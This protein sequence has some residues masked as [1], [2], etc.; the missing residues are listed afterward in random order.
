MV[1]A[2]PDADQQE[3]LLKESSGE[4][5]RGTSEVLK[6]VAKGS[7]AYPEEFKAE[8]E[9]WLAV[10][11]DIE[12]HSR[13]WVEPFASSKE[14]SD[15]GRAASQAALTAQLHSLEAALGESNRFAA[16]A[17][18][19]ST[20][21]CIAGTPSLSIADIA[22]LAAVQPLLSYVMGAEAR[23]PFPRTV[24]WV[25]EDAGQ[26]ASVAKVMGRI[27]LSPAPQGWVAPP[28]KDT[29]KKKKE[30]GGGGGD[31]QPQAPENGAGAADAELDPEKAAKKAAK[32]AEKEAKAAKL[33]AKKEAAAA[34]AAAQAAKKS[35]AGEGAGESKKAAAEAK[36]KAEA[37]EAARLK[38]EVDAVPK[39]AKKDVS[40]AAGKAYNP[41]I[42]EA[43]WYDWWEAS[44]YFKPDMNSTKPPFVIVIPPPNVTG[45]LHIGHALT[46]SIQDTIVRW[47]RMSGYNTVWVPGTDHA[48]IA[49]Q[50]IVEKTLQR[51]KGVSRHQLGRE[52][53]LEEVYKWVDVY[54]GRIT[55]QL[56]RIGSSVDWSRCVF[57]MD[58]QMSRA[59]NEAFVRMYNDGAIYRDNRLVNWC[60]KLKTAVSDIEVEY[61]DVPKRTLMTVPGYTEPVEFGVLT[62]FAYPLEGGGEI[63]VATTRPE[64]MLGD[65]AVAVHPEDPRYKHL[66]GKFAVHPLNQRRIPIICDAELVDMN[67][68]TGAVKITPAHDPNDFKTG[69]RHNLESINVFDDDGYINE[70]GGEFAGQPRF[71]ARVTVVEAL[72]KLG[73]FRGTTDNPMRFGICS[74]SKDVIEPCLK[75]QWWVKCDT[76]AAKSCAAVRSGELEIIPKEFEVV[77]FRWLENIRD[78]CISR[79]LWW[80]HR[81]PAYY[82][83]MEGETGQPGMLSEDTKRW[84]VGHNREEA[85][86]LASSRYPGCKFNLLQ[87]EDVLDTWFSSGLFPFSV[88]KWPEIS[89]DLKKFYP[90]SLLETGHDILFFWVARMVMMGL[91]L[92]GQVPFK[93]VYLHAMVRDAH[94]RKMSKSLGNVVDPLHVIDGISLEGLHQTLLSGNLDAKEVERAKAGQRTDFPDGI[95]ECGTDALRFGLCAYTSQARDINLDIKRIVAYR[96]WCNK[97]YNAIR[98]ASMNLPEDYQPPAHPTQLDM[99]SLPATPRW[100]LSKLSNAS[101][102]T[103]K[104]MEAYEF[105]NA[106]QRVYCFWQYELCDVYIELMKPIM[107]MD[108]SSPEQVAT[109]RATRDVLW[110][111]LETGLRLLHPFMPFVTEELW[112][113]LP[114]P[115]GVEVSPS[116][117]LAP[118]PEGVPA[119]AN[120]QLEA[121]YSYLM[122]CVSKVRSLRSDYGLL[123]QRPHLYLTVSDAGKA[124][125]LERSK[126]E[127]STLTNSSEVSV[128]PSGS[129]APPMGCGVAIVDDATVAHL[130]LKGILDPALEVA[131]LQKKLADVEQRLEGM[132][133]KMSMPGYAEKTPEAVRNDHAEAKA[134]M[135]A[136]RLA[137]V[138]QLLGMQQLA[139]AK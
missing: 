5:F 106:T 52:G 46:N 108:D 2:P 1:V 36:R 101:A 74:R 105:A 133:K 114:K 85:H 60:C 120:P 16:A 83:Q 27:P 7:S 18:Q 68:G 25:L 49:T 136:E 119:W 14:Y 4:S 78:W 61:I 51:E 125:V 88:F 102:G 116:I 62:S 124:A 81:I 132:V 42:V 35:A 76:M 17:Q 107:A 86:A 139:D 70:Q 47:R 32:Q 128:L 131:K 6:R 21:K 11:V 127:L 91:Q 59:V 84:V 37:E 55:N 94:G 24:Q 130:M 138:Q 109:K 28:K 92:T 12:Q 98:F 79:Q 123:K 82:V 96:H 43:T 20:A 104:A 48:G 72:D 69:K 99:S 90:G 97:L 122:E 41:H 71:K 40:K 135:E 9:K 22:L 23:A 26:H 39:G 53:F 29:K 50:T 100:L 77:W 134:R 121:E 3:P 54:G 13:A 63:V 80:G 15:E 64:T 8:V 45:A 129:A 65:T 89:E 66:H 113:R 67:F 57:T 75:P 95:E 38:A 93:Q 115:Q 19:G 33:A 110:I 126:L 117:M 111:A 56:R 30:G 73:L 58:P 44:G 10:A 34:A 87:D 112:Q 103:V 118:Y 137:T 31:K